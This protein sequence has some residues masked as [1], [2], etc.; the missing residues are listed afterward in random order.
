M[1]VR[2]FE[3]I[4]DNKMRAFPDVSGLELLSCGI[5][6]FAAGEFSQNLGHLLSVA[7]L[8]AF[9]KG[10]LK[11]GPIAIGVVMR[12]V[13]N[14]VVMPAAIA[15]AADFFGPVSGRVWS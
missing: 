7:N 15:E 4:A 1:G 3:L 2:W 6:K 10:E 8:L 9:D 13:I 14:K 12:R 11:S 5:E